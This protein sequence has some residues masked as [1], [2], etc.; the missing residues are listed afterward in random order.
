MVSVVDHL[1]QSAVTKLF[2]IPTFAN[3]WKIW[4]QR[5]QEILGNPPTVDSVLS[6]GSNL[7][8]VFRS[9]GESG[10]NQGSLSGGGAAWESLVAW[11]MNLGLLGSRSVVIKSSKLVPTSIKSA[12][13]VMYGNS[14]SNTES[15]LV[16]ITFPDEDATNKDLDSSITSSADGYKE[17]LYGF[18]SKRLSGISVC[19][20]QCKTNWNDNAQIPMLWDMVYRAKKFKDTNVSVGRDGYS[21]NDLRE[22]SYCF[23]TVPSNKGKFKQNSTAVNR[24]RS[25][26]G[27]NYW[28]QPSV[29]SVASSIGDIFQRNFE[30]GQNQGFRADLESGLQHLSDEYAYF[31]IS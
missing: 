3:A 4:R 17:Y 8:D 16:G 12:I 29:P 6:L 9:T 27:G 18:V 25:L 7:S 20:I 24:V 23:V 19:N 30:N 21:L 31:E 11:Y 15:D 5:I 13:T 2:Q 14:P 26:S 1:R 10:R 28:G 22:F